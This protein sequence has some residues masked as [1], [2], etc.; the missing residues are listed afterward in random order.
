MSGTTVRVNALVEG[1]FI[2]YD[3]AR[4]AVTGLVQ[5]G[6]TTFVAYEGAVS[7]VAVTI[8]EVGSGRYLYSFKPNAA[9]DWYIIIRHATYNARGWDEEFQA[10][11][12]G[13]DGGGDGAEE[14]R[15]WQRT[16]A[17]DRAIRDRW[18]RSRLSEDERDAM[19]RDAT[20]IAIIEAVDDDE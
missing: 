17:R 14:N 2:V 1:L 13:G 20:L 3:S 9:G 12:G 16:P 4:V 8:T 7:A 5:S 6:F 15:Q 11:P 18:A 10:L 19:L